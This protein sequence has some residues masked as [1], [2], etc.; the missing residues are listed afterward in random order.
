[1]SSPV[2]TFRSVQVSD[3][4][5]VYGP[6]RI[7][8]SEVQ[9]A[10]YEIVDRRVGRSKLVLLQASLVVLALA[11]AV[12]FAFREDWGPV[13]LF[14][15]CGGWAYAAMDR[16]QSKAHMRRASRF[17]VYIRTRGT[18]LLLCSWTLVGD[19]QQKG[20]EKLRCRELVDAIRTRVRPESGEQ[21]EGE[22]EQEMAPA[23]ER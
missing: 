23:F 16:Y 9:D 1:M 2:F 10:R 12:W 17:S 19:Y 8:L 15:A 6:R 3:R 20:A 14:L 4:E 21:S 22:A 7:A 11:P 5:L 18:E 13:L